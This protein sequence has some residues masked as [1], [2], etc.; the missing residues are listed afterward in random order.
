MNSKAVLIGLVSCGCCT[1]GCTCHIHQDIGMGYP[2]KRC[3]QH[4]GM[5]NWQWQQMYMAAPIIN[6]R[7]THVVQP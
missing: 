5:N 6:G 7:P 1:N 4:Q 3:D 2:A